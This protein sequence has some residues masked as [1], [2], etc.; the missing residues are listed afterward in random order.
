MFSRPEISS[1]ECDESGYPSEAST[2]QTVLSADQTSSRPA[3][4]SSPAAIMISSR[5]EPR[6][7]SITWVS[8]SPQRQL[9]SK[10]FGPGSGSDAVAVGPGLGGR[11]AGVGQARVG[12]PYK[13]EVVDGGADDVLEDGRV[14]GGLH[15]HDR[16]VRPHPPGVRPLVLVVSPLVVLGREEGKDLAPVRDDEDR[17]LPPFQAI[18]YD[19]PLPRRS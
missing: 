3:R 15:P 16:G 5:S 1:P 2:T 4:S 9:H 10:A 8:G 12:R 14:G 18:L 19:D 6:R 13:G 11:G 17:S 7:G